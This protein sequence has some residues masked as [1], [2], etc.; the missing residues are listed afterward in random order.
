MKMLRL[1]MLMYL[2]RIFSSETIHDA[3]HY[4]YF[5]AVLFGSLVLKPL[6]LHVQ[7]QVFRAKD[8]NIMDLLYNVTLDG[9]KE[10][11]KSAVDGTE[12]AKNSD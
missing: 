2:T 7:R 6:V 9:N 3:W 12:D 10:D 11:K 1:K 8:L 4:T 5:E